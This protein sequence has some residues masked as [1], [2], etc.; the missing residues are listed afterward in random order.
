VD[1]SP[2]FSSQPMADKLEVYTKGTKAWFKDPEE[3]YIVASLVDKT[4]T[5]KNIVLK[6]V[7]DGSKQV[8]WT[9]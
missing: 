1:A 2:F 7:L 8:F 4:V 3:G 5:E 6:F 9:Q